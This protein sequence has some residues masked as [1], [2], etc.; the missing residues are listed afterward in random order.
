MTA[1][2]T[3]RRCERTREALL[4]AFLKLLFERG[5]QDMSVGD[6]VAAANVGR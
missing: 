5:Y 1:V 6:I 2:E 3:D 4:S